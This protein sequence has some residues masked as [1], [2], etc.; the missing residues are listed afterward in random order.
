MRHADI[1][2]NMKA[3]VARYRHLVRLRSIARAH[4]DRT[5]NA[6]Y[7]EAVWYRID[8]KIEDISRALRAKRPMSPDAWSMN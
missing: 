5:G 8:V 2:E 1:P 6:R 4:W 7:I 3:T